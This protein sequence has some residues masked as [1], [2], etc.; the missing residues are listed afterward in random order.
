MKKQE[1]SLLKKQPLK[2]CTSRLQLRQITA[3]DTPAIVMLRSDPMAYRFFRRP[4]CLTPEEHIQWYE[5]TYLADE[6]RFDWLALH[7]GSPIGLFG[8]NRLPGAP[9]RVEISYLLAPQGQGR[10]YA[11]E[12]VHA[13]LQW[14]VRE[15]QGENA[16]AEIHRANRASLRFIRRMGFYLW[17]ECP[18]FLIFQK[19]LT[20]EAN[21]LPA[22]C[23]LTEEVLGKVDK[24]TELP[25]PPPECRLLAAAFF[26]RAFEKKRG[27]AA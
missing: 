2:L 14:A 15:W 1:S 18:P 3:E 9:V 10:G 19:D 22:I 13:L 8:L 23:R 6:N 20:P 25:P 21:G 24:K 26:A 7:D 17:K 11:A 12:A 5:K 27:L 4:H 16:F